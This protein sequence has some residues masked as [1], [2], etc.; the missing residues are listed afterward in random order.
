MYTRIAQYWIVSGTD[1]SMIYEKAELY[2]SITFKLIQICT[3]Q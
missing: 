3:N 1:L 2:N